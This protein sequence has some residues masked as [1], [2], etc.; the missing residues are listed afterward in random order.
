MVLAVSARLGLVL[1]LVGV[2]L[3]IIS[4]F[5]HWET[6]SG[7]VGL[8]TAPIGII[9]L[10]IGVI[11]YW[12]SGQRGES[13]LNVILEYS[14]R[15]PMEKQGREFIAAVYLT[16]KGL[17]TEVVS[18]LSDV[19][20]ETRQVNIRIDKPSFSRTFKFIV[21]GPERNVKETVRD[22][23]EFCSRTKKCDAKPEY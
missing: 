20:A 8:E 23:V 12:R 22:V 9:L 11:V 13:P 3:I 7:F 4:P 5:M 21:S 17:E 6:E 18:R 19:L 10:I 14:R 15:E 16:S 2:I 1:I